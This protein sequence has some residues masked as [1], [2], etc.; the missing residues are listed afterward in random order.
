LHSPS[1]TPA[2]SPVRNSPSKLPRFLEHAEKTLG[3]PHATLHQY[4]L[5]SAGYGPD[6]L[7][8]VNDSALTAI[9][10]SPG[11]A[12]R[13]KREAP[14]WWNGPLAKRKLTPADQAETPPEPS[15]KR[16]VQLEKRWKDGSGAARYMGSIGE[17]DD[18]DDND[19]CDW[20]YFSDATESFL[21]IPCGY[22]AIL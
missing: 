10:L 7:D 13:L 14:I 4:A 15:K 18:I 21:P 12:I 8:V 2:S 11:D 6:I 9:G 3:I 5:E 20:F 22:A 16:R 19:E 1:R 17:S